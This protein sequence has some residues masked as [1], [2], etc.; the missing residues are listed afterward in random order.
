MDEEAKQ[1]LREMRDIA[2]RSEARAEAAVARQKRTINLCL[3]LLAI[4]FSSLAYLMWL[5]TTGDARQ[6]ARQAGVVP[7]VQPLQNRT[8]D[9][10]RKKGRSW[11]LKETSRGQTDRK[12]D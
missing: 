9:Q 11:S 4:V 7:E 2:L 1:L 10:D 8:D 12:A 5:L 3:L 6:P